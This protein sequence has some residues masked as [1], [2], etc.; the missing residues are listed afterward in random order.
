M[1]WL[2][3]AILTPM[4]L[5][6]LQ[7]WISTRP[8]GAPNDPLPLERRPPGPMVEPR[9]R[10]VDPDEVYDELN[11]L[12]VA[13]GGLSPQQAAPL[14]GEYL[15][16]SGDTVDN[17][18]PAHISAGKNW[19]G[20]WAPVPVLL[21]EDGSPKYRLRAI[22]DYP[23]LRMGILDW[24]NGLPAAA[25][26]AILVGDVETFA[27]AMVAGQRIGMHAAAYAAYVAEAARPWVERQQRWP[28]AATGAALSGYGRD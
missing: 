24:I 10:K 6:L 23:S 16:A 3:P 9:A 15:L 27:A 20:A 25:R 21:H 2:L 13:Q 12:F 19:H 11:R 8:S 4:V 7:R 22:R 17:N 18:N 14:I 1:N 26:E 28:G 5:F